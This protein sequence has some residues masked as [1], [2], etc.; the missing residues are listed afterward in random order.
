MAFGDDHLQMPRNRGADVGSDH[1]IVAATL[2]LKLTKTGAKQQGRQLSD[3]EKLTDPNQ[4]ACL[5]YRLETGFK[6]LQ[7]LKTTVRKI[8]ITTIRSL[9]P[10]R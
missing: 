8:R 7:L 6:L 10:K 2:K 9:R 3:V 1:M 5:F 4:E